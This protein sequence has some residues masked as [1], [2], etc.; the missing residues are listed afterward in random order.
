MTRRAW[1]PSRVRI[2]P[3]R[4]ANLPNKEM[5]KAVGAYLI[6]DTVC[7]DRTMSAY[8]ADRRLSARDV[9][10]EKITRV[11]NVIIVW[12]ERGTRAYDAATGKELWQHPSLTYHSFGSSLIDGTRYLPDGNGKVAESVDPRTGKL[13]W[14][15]H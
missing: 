9:L 3:L 13:R 5:L 1:F 11:C 10:P 12:H 14:S 6:P 15:P 2:Y 7:G 8:D 4:I